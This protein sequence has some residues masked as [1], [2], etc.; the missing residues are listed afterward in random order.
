MNERSSP[1]HSK[2]HRK[3]R[4]SRKSSRHDS[5][6]RSSS[7]SR[8]RERRPRSSRSR[9]PSRSRNRSRRKRRH[10]SS[11]SDR[12]DKKKLEEQKQSRFSATIAT[13]LRVAA[14]AGMH[15]RMMAGGRPRESKKM[16][17]LYVGQLPPNM[18]TQTVF[19]LFDAPCKML[20]EC[21]EGLPPVRGVVMG[22]NGYYCHVEMQSLALAAAAKGIFHNIELRGR[23]LIVRSYYDHPEHVRNGNLAAM[24][25]MN[26]MGNMNALSGMLGN[27]MLGNALNPGWGAMMPQ[28]PSMVLGNPSP[29]DAAQQLLSVMSPVPAKAPAPIL[30]P[31]PPLPPKEIAIPPELQVTPGAASSTKADVAPP[32]PV[33]TPSNSSTNIDA[34]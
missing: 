3:H 28:M 20:P 32:L 34:S 18:T 13:T 30:V 25:K 17:E 8:S 16:R 11:K 14:N 1:K 26:A 12:K 27:G 23:R 10:K 4:S 5:H 19:Q 21:T 7:K 2:K 22:R 9:S 33:S 6:R 15:P 24:G 31:Q 29:I